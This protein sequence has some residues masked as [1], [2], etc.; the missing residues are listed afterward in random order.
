[1]ENGNVYFLENAYWLTEFEQE[2]LQFPVGKHDDQVDAFA[3]IA[4]LIEPMTNSLPQSI[5][6]TKTIKERLGLGW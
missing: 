3:Y 1:M 4:Q 5:N 6:I 2:L